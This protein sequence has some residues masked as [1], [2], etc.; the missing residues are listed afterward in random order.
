MNTRVPGWVP[1]ATMRMQAPENNCVGRNCGLG[2]KGLAVSLSLVPAVM[3]TGCTFTMLHVA[4]QRKR[5]IARFGL[6][7]EG[8]AAHRCACCCYPCALWRHTIF[9]TEMSAKRKAE[10]DTR[11]GGPQ[12]VTLQRS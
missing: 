7:Q 5:I 2:P 4:K 9:L 3:L 12:P 10:S 8:Q 6:K 11:Q 1:T